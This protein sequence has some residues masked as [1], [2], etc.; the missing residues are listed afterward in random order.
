MATFKLDPD[1]YKRIV[2]LESDLRSAAD[3]LRNDFDEKSERWQDSAVGDLT[4][5]WIDDLEE[6][7]D[8]LDTVS[9]KPED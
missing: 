6:V 7:V 2:E 8:R 3:D 1:L 5:A 4:R 9:K